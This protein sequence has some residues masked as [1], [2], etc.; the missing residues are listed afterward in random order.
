MSD[1]LRR[2][3]QMIAQLPPN[4]LQTQLFQEVLG[5]IKR[6]RGKLDTVTRPVPNLEDYERLRDLYRDC[7][8]GGIAKDKEINRLREEN[9]N[10]Q[11]DRDKYRIMAEGT[12]GSVAAADRMMDEF[13]AGKGG[14]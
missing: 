13:A 4:R 11:H 9:H 8:E 7:T 2:M 1:L 14:K 10:L 6:L 12:H 3:R 5:E